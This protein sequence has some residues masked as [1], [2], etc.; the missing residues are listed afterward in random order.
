MENPR[1]N[2]HLMT[3]LGYGEHAISLGP[4]KL[5]KTLAKCI[6]EVNLVLSMPPSPQSQNVMRVLKKNLQELMGTAEPDPDED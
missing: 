2:P 5:G 6:S 1:K 4:K 3:D